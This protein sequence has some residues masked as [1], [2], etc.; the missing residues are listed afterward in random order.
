MK[1][2]SYHVFLAVLL[3]IS[4]FFSCTSNIE[5]PPHPDSFV[6]PGGSSSSLTYNSS[7]NEESSSSTGSSSSSS[8]DIPSSSS[9]PEPEITGFFEFR[10]FDYS[11]SSSKIYFLGTSISSKI[12]N[13]LAIINTDEAE[14]DAIVIEV[15]GGGLTGM[16]GVVIETGEISASAVATCH[17]EKITLQTATATVVSDP[18]FSECALP[19]TYVYKS[20][21]VKNLVTV[22]NNYGRCANIEY[23][24]VNY[25][26]SA[27]TMPQI[28]STTASCGSFTKTCSG[29]N[30]AAVAENYLPFDH[31]GEKVPIFNG[32]MVIE[33][34]DGYDRY[35]TMTP[36][37][38]IGC[39]NNPAGTGQISFKLNGGT[40]FTN[41]WQEAELPSYATN[42]NRVLLEKVSTLPAQCVVM[43]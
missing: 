39:E 28:F 11:S 37:T 10:N 21:S 32:T 31:E 23:A 25:P 26:S 38:K 35:G 22:E 24:P 7:S 6:E 41:Y 34:L 5:L 3:C 2:N 18:V 19:S 16:T 27:S 42:G 43:F 9:I 14:C 8:P 33:M 13:T 12:H 40:T 36:V 1:F 30:I 20:E 17:G 29:L 4:L 15:T